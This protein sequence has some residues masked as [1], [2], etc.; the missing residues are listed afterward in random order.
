MALLNGINLDK[1]TEEF[2]VLEN[3]ITDLNGKTILLETMLEDAN[4]QVKFYETKEKA[5]TEERDALL[6]TVNQ[7]QQAL[8]DQCDLRVENE[9]LKSNMEIL[10]QQSKRKA[11]DGK[12]ELQRLLCE[13]KAHK[14]SHK[15]ELETVKQE[16]R[17]QV[18]ET[19]KEACSQLQAKEVE[20]MR[21]MEQKD[22]DL[23]EMKTKLKDQE[24]KQQ[25]ELLKLQ[26]EFGEK[27]GRIQNT[28]Q[29]NQHQQKEH[30]SVLSAQHFFKRKLQFIQ[31]E[32]NK[33]IGVLRQRIKELEDNQRIGNL[34]SRSKKRRT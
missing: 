8:Q 21:L 26:I 6:V 1:L 20:V 13:M 5:V 17:R 15:R 31:E 10:K 14:E 7:L 33:E 22:L 12:T 3:T 25:S 27:L 2:I 30:E 34:C 4:R 19:H 29:M 32:K 9:T 11:E 23:E 24:R 28:A 16:C 18:E